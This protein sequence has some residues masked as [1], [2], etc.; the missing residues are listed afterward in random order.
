MMEKGE[1]GFEDGGRKHIV[2]LK[3][4]LNALNFTA[5]FKKHFS[6][7]IF[8]NVLKTGTNWN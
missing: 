4:I 2:K 6:I 8:I 7:Y 1:K 3:I 5:Y